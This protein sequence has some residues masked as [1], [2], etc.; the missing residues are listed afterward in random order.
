MT[1]IQML[2]VQVMMAVDE[3]KEQDGTVPCSFRLYESD[4]GVALDLTADGASVGSTICKLPSKL[5]SVQRMTDKDVMRAL[6]EI[7]N[8][9]IREVNE[10]AHQRLVG[11]R[12]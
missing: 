8:A 5:S 9:Q 12:E 1:N 3:A 2:I 10:K 6:K 11:Y 4:E 7:G